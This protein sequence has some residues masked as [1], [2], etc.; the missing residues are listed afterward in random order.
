M[1][2]LFV[3]FFPAD[4]LF[5]QL[6]FPQ[7]PGVV[8]YTYRKYF[9]KDVPST[10]DIIKANGFTDIE[11][12]NLFGKTAA[13]L[14]KLIDERGLKCSSFGVS[15][16][17]FINKT[18][19]VAQ[20]AKTLGAD[21][22]RVAGIPHKGVFTLE[23][24][25]QAIDDFNRTGKLLKEQYSLSF[26]YHNHGFEFEP[27]KT[28]TLFNLLVEQTDPEYVSFEL[29]ILWAFFPGQDPAKMLNKYPG[30]FKLMHLKDLK[31]GVKGNLSGGTSRDNDVALGTGQMDLPAI[32]K[33][34]KQ[35]GIQHYY[36]ED[37]S[38]NVMEQV[39]ASIAYLKS[40]TE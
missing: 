20:N 10:L 37:E 2:V 23:E 29:D 17:D 13:E 35:A 38:N 14:R 9:E 3:C 30:R 4:K 12:S 11:F 24:A 31:K 39:P 25:Q 26:V 19:L 7:K 18:A 40:L 16:E 21:Y 33:A 28:G 1:A 36:I 32:L 6:L 27:Y 15:Y 22:V 8:S 34:A 5:A